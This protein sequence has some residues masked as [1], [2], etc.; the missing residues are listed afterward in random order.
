MFCCILKFSLINEL[1]IQN[2]CHLNFHCWKPHTLKVWHDF[3]SLSVLSHQTCFSQ[4]FNLASHWPRVLLYMNKVQYLHTKTD[5]CVCKCALW[6]TFQIFWLDRWSICLHVQYFLYMFCIK[7]YVN[8]L[9]LF[10]WKYKKFNINHCHW[11]VT[12]LCTGQ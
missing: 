10:G 4:P 1:D 5:H 9:I 7:F 3:L 2:F 12:F 11:K 6:Q 8:I